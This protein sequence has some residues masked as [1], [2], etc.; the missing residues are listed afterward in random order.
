[1]EPGAEAD[2]QVT[3][4]RRLLLPLAVC[5]LGVLIGVFLKGAGN[6][7]IADTLLQFG[8]YVLFIAVIA[9]V[10]YALRRGR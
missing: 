2:P 3:P 8:G 1:M 10:V 4:L 6:T 7:S 9:G 5:A